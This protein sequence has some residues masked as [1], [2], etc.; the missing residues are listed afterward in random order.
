M[1]TITL[2]PRGSGYHFAMNRD[3]RLSREAAH[4][5]EIVELDGVRAAYPYEPSTRGTWIAVNDIGITLA[6]LNWNFGVPRKL[7]ERSRG[8]LIPRIIGGRSFPDVE[9]RLSSADFSGILP[10]RLFGVFPRQHLVCEWRWDRQLLRH[11]LLPWQPRHWFSSGLSD[12]QADQ[13][14]GRITAAAWQESDAGT[15]EWI[16]RLHRS[17]QPEPGAFSICVHRDDAQTVSFTEIE[18]EENK[19]MMRYRPGS[20][21]ASA[22]SVNEVQLTL[23]PALAAIL[24]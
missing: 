18:L 9:R 15:S 23:V 20:P 17:H 11:E 24:P 6:V 21:C 4:P 13:N 3:E 10:F 12:E 5:P 7:R 8:S 2:V 14:R 22:T 16:W 19:L 1:C